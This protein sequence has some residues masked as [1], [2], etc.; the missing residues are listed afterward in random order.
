MKKCIDKAAIEN[1][2]HKL[3]KKD[4]GFENIDIAQI[5]Y[6]RALQDVQCEM[7]ALEVQEETV[8]IWHDAS[9][10]PNIKEKGGIF[11]I[12]ASNSEYIGSRYY[13]RNDDTIIFGNYDK[14]AYLNDLANLSNVEITVKDRKEEPVSENLEEVAQEYTT[15]EGYLAGLHY[16]S[17]VQSFKAG[18][19]WY[20]SHN[21]KLPDNLL[22]A[23]RKASIYMCDIDDKYLDEYPYHPIA[24][25]KF[26]EGANWQKEQIMKD[27]IDATVFCESLKIPTIGH[28]LHKTNLKENDKVKVI[29]IKSE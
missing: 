29:I 17:M 8:N 18:A 21:T 12:T 4:T 5:A 19:E 6:N 20:A 27:A 16:N 11:V 24:E 15:K 28:F 3:W 26:K 25:Q 7:D 14:W 10:K 22:L 9:V 23:A 2:L 13:S 1:I